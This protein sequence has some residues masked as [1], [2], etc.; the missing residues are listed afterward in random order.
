MF[1]R[2]PQFVDFLLQL[3]DAAK[4]NVLV[5]LKAVD[6]LHEIPHQRA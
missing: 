6:T 1:G 4:L 5:F 2:A 3:R